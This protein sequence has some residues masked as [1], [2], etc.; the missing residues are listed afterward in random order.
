MYHT[1]GKYAGNYIHPTAWIGDNVEMGKGN[2]IEAGA[3]IGAAGHLQTHRVSEMEGTI[4]IG[5]N[6]RIGANSVIH[7]GVEGVTVIGNNNMIM[8]FV[9]IGHDVVVRSNIE[10]CPHTIICG[11]SIIEEGVKIKSN[12]IVSPKRTLSE[13]CFIYSA[14]NVTQSTEKGCSYKGSPAKKIEKNF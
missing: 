7:Y 1:Q 9:N 8:A 12:C 5:D 6:N 3:V 13:G 14:S 2:Y 10:I 4:L 11:H